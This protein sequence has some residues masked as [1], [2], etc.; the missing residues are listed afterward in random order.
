MSIAVG[1]DRVATNHWA[2]RTPAVWTHYTA[3][4]YP[5]LMSLAILSYHAL[6]RR[7]SIPTRRYRALHPR[8]HCDLYDPRRRRR[9]LAG[10]RAIAPW[11]GP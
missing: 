9:L 6:H 7:T 10:E 11:L 5:A 4:H 8:M 3:L 1:V 2:P